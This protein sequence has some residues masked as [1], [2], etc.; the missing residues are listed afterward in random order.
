MRNKK[1]IIVLGEEKCGKSTIIYALKKMKICKVNGK[2][3]I[4]GNKKSRI[5]HN[6]RGDCF[7]NLSPIDDN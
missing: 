2:Y 1:G 4:E 5:N 7:I 6:V 3:E